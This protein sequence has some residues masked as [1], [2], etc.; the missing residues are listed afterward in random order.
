MRLTLN[1]H[2]VFGV[3]L[4]IFLFVVAFLKSWDIPWLYFIVSLVGYAI[5]IISLAYTMENSQK[6]EYFYM[7]GTHRRGSENNESLIN[8]QKEL[9]YNCVRATIGSHI[10][11]ALLILGMVFLPSDYTA[12]MFHLSYMIASIAGGMAIPF[13]ILKISY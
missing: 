1:K 8:E 13:L 11:F 5:V 10:S 6:E 7:T 3:I 12:I 2:G 9:R 4:I